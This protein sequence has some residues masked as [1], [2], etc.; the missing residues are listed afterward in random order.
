MTHETYVCVVL[1]S[2]MLAKNTDDSLT[3]NTTKDGHIRC[4][5]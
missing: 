4:K 3:V 5:D 1:A 2:V